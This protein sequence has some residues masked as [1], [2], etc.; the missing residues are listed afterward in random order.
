MDSQKFRKR[1]SN[2]LNTKEGAYAMAEVAFN[3]L[4]K[5]FYTEYTVGIAFERS[6]T[7]A[8]GRLELAS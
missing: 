6:M 5:P 8:D 4:W 3:Q 1:F 2:F 7:L